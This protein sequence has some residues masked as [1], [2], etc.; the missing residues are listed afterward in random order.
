MPVLKQ[1]TA[2]LGGLPIN[3]GR[4]ASGADLGSGAA[5]EQFGQTTQNTLNNITSMQEND[6][7]RTA[8]V[9]STQIRAK[10]SE[11]LDQAQASGADTQ[12]L[13]EEMNNELATIGN[14]FATTHGHESLDLYTSN[15][16]ISFEN[17]ANA[18]NVERAAADAKAKGNEWLNAQSALLSRDPTELASS[19]KDAGAFVDTF[20][21]LPPEQRTLIKQH[22]TQQL[23]M[24]AALSVAR[25]NP[26]DAKNKLNNGEWDLTPAQ[27]QQALR[28][29]DYSERAIRSEQAAARAEARQQK[30]DANESASS[31]VISLIMQGKAKN[32][33]FFN[34]ALTPAAR[35]NLL[36][37]Q[38][39]WTRERDSGLK[40]SDPIAKRNLWL[41]INA[42]NDDPNKILTIDP[43]FKQVQE[44]KLNTQ[45][46]NQLIGM[47]RSSPDEQGN[48]FRTRLAMRMNNMGHAIYSDPGYSDIAADIQNELLA[49]AE[50]AAQ[51]MR[52][53][54][55]DP[56]MML[57]PSSKDYFFKPG[58]IKSTADDIRQQ[59]APKYPSVQNQ[60]EYDALKPGDVYMD[61]TTGQTH[62][63][64]GSQQESYGKIGGR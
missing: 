24:S 19:V 36:H 34:P 12:K 43:I 51:T 9:K 28:D 1:Y 14:D 18:I 26:V 58:L 25:V 47:L 55:Q 3:G 61:A 63:K 64:Q 56:N 53:N 46:A 20:S 41:G 31:D 32:L 4:P 11:L 50:D 2:D 6:E 21:S 15:A 8:L 35:E 17:H 27:R 16:N 38:D 33:D 7:A 45:D 23:N 52:K 40:R 57:D 29:A 5:L 44:G 42:P 59:L 62:I 10:Y 22:L 48:K 39:W 13:R 54:G 37:F 49:K 60:D 30:V